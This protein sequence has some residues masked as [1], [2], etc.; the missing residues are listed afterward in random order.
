M[1]F[2]VIVLKQ[3]DPALYFFNEDKWGLISEGGE[4]F[5]KSGD[6][7]DSDGNRFKTGRIK[8]I[9]KASWLTCLMSFKRMSRVY[10]ETDP[11]STV[12]LD[13]FKQ[14][15]VQ[16]IQR[17]PSYWAQKDFVEFMLPAIME[18]NSYQEI[19]EYLK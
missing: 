6:I 19:I 14:V 3:K 10:L 5:Y 13:E 9:R 12:S 7:Y 8:G 18:K 16:H 4:T 17:Y 11:V 1:I 2:P 15:I